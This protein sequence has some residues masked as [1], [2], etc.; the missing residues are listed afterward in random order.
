ME[1]VYVIGVAVKIK[2]IFLVDIRGKW[3]LEI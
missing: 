1:T 2:I 3:T